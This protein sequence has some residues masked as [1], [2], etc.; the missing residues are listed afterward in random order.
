MHF[1]HRR[2]W[3]VST[4]SQRSRPSRPRTKWTEHA[5]SKIRPSKRL[6]LCIFQ[7]SSDTFR[8][9]QFVHIIIVHN[10]CAPLNPPSQPAKWW[11]S[12]S[13]AIKKTSNRIANTLPKLRTNPPKIA[14][15]QNYE[16]T[17]VSELFISRDT[18]SIRHW[19]WPGEAS[20]IQ[21]KW[22][23]PSPRSLKALL[24][25]SLSKKEQNTGMQR[26]R[27]RYGASSIH[28]HCPEPRSSSHIGQGYILGKIECRRG[29]KIGAH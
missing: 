21:C 2:F 23:P 24:F 9:R 10:F 6:E 17:G 1:V 20:T 12:S 18:C 8:K 14:N 11:I 13:I 27:A 25:P 15:K 19:I 4:E 3:E 29:E 5:S 7:T 26:V 22:S 16:Q 28:F